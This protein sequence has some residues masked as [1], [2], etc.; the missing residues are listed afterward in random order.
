MRSV[1][2]NDTD[3]LRKTKKAIE[4][5]QTPSRYVAVC[6]R[7]AVKSGGRFVMLPLSKTP[8]SKQNNHRVRSSM[9]DPVKCNSSCCSES[10]TGCIGSPRWCSHHNSC[11]EDSRWEKFQGMR[12][13][14]EGDVLALLHTASSAVTCKAPLTRYSPSDSSY[15]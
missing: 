4:K 14:N 11:S 12:V 10:S 5:G 6:K 15:N 7:D 13:I 9:I 8:S 1:T 2:T 3:E